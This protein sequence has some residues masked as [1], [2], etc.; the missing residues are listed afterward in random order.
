MSLY[1]KYLVHLSKWRVELGVWEVIIFSCSRGNH[2]FLLWSVLDMCR[3]S[4]W[5][6]YHSLDRGGG[7]G[8]VYDYPF[9]RESHSYPDMDFFC[10]TVT[11]FVPFGVIENTVT[12]F[13]SK[14]FNENFHHFICLGWSI[15]FLYAPAHQTWLFEKF[16]FELYAS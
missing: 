9:Q 10:Y 12:K 2:I 13:N 7:G 4:I 11:Y 5:S 3:F 6:T 8:L 1:L 16:I 14:Y 15:L